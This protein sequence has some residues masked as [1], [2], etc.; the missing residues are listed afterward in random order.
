[1]YALRLHHVHN[2]DLTSA[3]VASL[4]SRRGVLRTAIARVIISR[5]TRIAVIVAPF[6]HIAFVS[7]RIQLTTRQHHIVSTHHCCW[8]S[9]RNCHWL[10][11]IRWRSSLESSSG[12][13]T[14]ANIMSVDGFGGKFL[15]P[16]T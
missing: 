16:H 12:F 11:G 7:H 9:D 4:L 14:M 10:A 3:K 8:S 1:M 15:S 2:H 5:A 6:I 13:P